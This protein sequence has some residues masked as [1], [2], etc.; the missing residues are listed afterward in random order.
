MKLIRG[1]FLRSLLPMLPSS[2][3]AI[4]IGV[5][6][7]G[8]S[9]LILN[10]LRP[11]ELFLV[12]PWSGGSFDKNSETHY[13]TGVITAH[14][15]SSHLKCIQKKF[16]DDIRARTVIIKQGFSYDVVDSFRDDFFDFIYID[17]CHFY[18]SVR[19]DLKS[20]LP[21]LKTGG[22]MCGHDYTKGDGYGVIQAV[23]EF[24]LDYNFEWVGELPWK[25]SGKRGTDWAIRRKS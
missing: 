22:L 21:K 19:A 17:A 9:E 7:G 3:T 10:N 5:Q 16:V 15:T 12:D 11:G 24:I 18:N 4:E 2:C 1:E 13:S 8:F 14:A 6:G 20:F 25:I 23:D